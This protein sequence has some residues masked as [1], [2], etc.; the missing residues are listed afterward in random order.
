[1]TVLQVNMAALHNV[2]LLH[3]LIYY[4]GIIVT[5]ELMYIW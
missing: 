4:V 3:V 1:M 2:E 5:L